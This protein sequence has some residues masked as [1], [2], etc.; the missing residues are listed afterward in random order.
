M[1]YGIAKKQLERNSI[2]YFI[3]Y[4]ALYISPMRLQRKSIIASTTRGDILMCK[5]L[6]MYRRPLNVRSTL[7]CV[8][9]RAIAVKA[10]F[11]C[12]NF[13]GAFDQFEAISGCKCSQACC[14]LSLLHLWQFKLLKGGHIAIYHTIRYSRKVYRTVRHSVRMNR[15]YIPLPAIYMVWEYTV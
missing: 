2:P 6:R 8:R 1:V 11:E 15:T 14:P 7:T 12:L 3:F 4:Q 5:S 10:N 9:G 13:G